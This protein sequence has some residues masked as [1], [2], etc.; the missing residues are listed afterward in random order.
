MDRESKII[1]LQLRNFETEF[2]TFEVLFLSPHLSFGGATKTCDESPSRYPSMP[3]RKVTRN[4]K[5]TGKKNTFCC[6]HV[7]CL[8]LGFPYMETPNFEQSRVAE[9]EMMFPTLF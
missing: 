4:A 8:W 9:M 3:G 7:M 1:H 5:N 2:G 6:V